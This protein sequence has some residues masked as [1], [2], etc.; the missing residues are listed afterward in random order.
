MID[1]FVKTLPFFALITL[2]YAAARSQFFMTEATANLT[3]FVFYFALPAMIFKFASQLSFAD[4]LDW[5]FIAAYTMAGFAVYGV[6]T[7]A[8]L[9]RAT[10]MAQ[11][12][13]EAQCAVIGNIGFLGI[14]MLALLLG[15]GAVVYVM[16]MLSVD[17]ILFGSLIVVLILFS[18]DGQMSWASA[19]VLAMGV[20]KNPMIGGIVLGLLWSSSGA[21]VPAPA[22]NFVDILGSAATPCALFVIGASLAGKSAERVSVAAWLSFCKLVL[23]P[24]AVAATALWIF[25]V[26]P[27]GAAVMIASA[28]LPVA[29]NIYIIAQHYG[30]ASMRVSSAILVSTTASVVTVSAVIAWVEPQQALVPCTF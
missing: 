6:A 25:S 7:F 23:H 11:A 14:P 5:Q 1:V 3:K 2:G 27:Y 19:R 15:P 22:M 9:R 30:V 8:A 16:I 12:A 28:S 17:L 20:L 26:E 10:G 4:I 24:L 18:R 29:G 21:S 13:V